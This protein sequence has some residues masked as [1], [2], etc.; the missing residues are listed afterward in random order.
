MFS[1]KCNSGMR[2][3][4]NW[5]LTLPVHRTDFPQKQC[6]E[7]I[8]VTKISTYMIRV[9]YLENF[10]IYSIYSSRVSFLITFEICIC[11]IIIYKIRETI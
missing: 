5:L 7:Q 2:L 4:L 11:K 6:Y 3:D 9:T 1:R 10:T 8:H